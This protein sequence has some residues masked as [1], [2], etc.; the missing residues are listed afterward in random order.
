MPRRRNP[1][2]KEI[3]T[4]RKSA[5]EITGALQRLTELVQRVERE[6]RQGAGATTGKRRL[7]ITPKRR[8]TL[9]LQGAYMGFMRQLGPRQKARVKAIKEKSGFRPAISLARKLAGK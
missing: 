3:R 5:R 2:R 8:A 1:I 7:R 9:K 4:I 6:S